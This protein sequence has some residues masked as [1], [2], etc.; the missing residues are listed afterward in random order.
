METND[1]PLAPVTGWE[2]GPVA[3]YGIG[4]LTLQYLVSPME[5]PEQAHASPTFALTSPQ[6]RELGQ[7]LIELSQKLE[8]TPQTSSGSPTH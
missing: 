4:I 3:A 6:L 1:I 8:T 5:S 2:L 7:K